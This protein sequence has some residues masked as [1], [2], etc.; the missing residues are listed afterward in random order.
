MAATGKIATD[1]PLLMCFCRNVN[2]ELV[3]DGWCWW[4]WK[5][6]PGDTVLEELEE[7]ERAAK[8]GL[9]ADPRPVQESVRGRGTRHARGVGERS[10]GLRVRVP[11]SPDAH[12]YESSEYQACS[13]E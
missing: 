12:R 7:E 8:K 1:A 4:Y 5:Y 11:S 2:H 10:G 3:K 6:A 9:W 13:N